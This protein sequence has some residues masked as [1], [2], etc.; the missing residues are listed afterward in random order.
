MK[1]IIL[2]LVL[3]VA[4]SVNSAPQFQVDV[5]KTL[6]Y[7][8]KGEALTGLEDETSGNAGLKFALDLKLYG[9]NTK[10]FSLMLSNPKVEDCIGKSFVRSPKQT[11]EF[12]QC[13]HFPTEIEMY[14]KNIGKIYFARN[15]PRFCRNIIR[16]VV[17]MFKITYKEDKTYEVQESGIQGDCDAKY[18]VNENGKSDWITITK[19]KNLM[20]CKKKVVQNI[21]MSYIH[22][23][24]FCPMKN[25]LLV[26]VLVSE[27]KVKFENNT[28]L[29]GKAEANELYKVSPGSDSETPVILKATQELTL[30]GVKIDNPEQRRQQQQQRQQQQAL[31]PQAQDE[32]RENIYY[33]FPDQPRMAVT[34]ME[35]RNIAEQVENV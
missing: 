23:L 4:G 32:G 29:I 28:I 27:H 15:T 6:L 30:T 5:G 26:G 11:Q 21:G 19:S 7:S 12:E 17:G 33:E 20:N 24:P 18:T 1:G 8:Y 9:I 25:R 35:T 10:R 3:T 31:W 34:V 22:A 2:A 14:G 16:G 13:C